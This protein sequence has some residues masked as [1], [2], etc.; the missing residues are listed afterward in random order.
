[1]DRFGIPSDEFRTQLIAAIRTHP[2]MPDESPATAYYAAWVEA[3]ENLLRRRGLS[4]PSSA[5]MPPRS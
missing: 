4:G 3:L 5:E 1:M 2:G